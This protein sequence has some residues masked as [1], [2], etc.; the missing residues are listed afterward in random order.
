MHVLF[1]ILFY[2][3]FLL[4]VV[5]LA[6]KIKQYAQT[7]AP[8]KIPTTPAPVT[9]TGVVWRL[10]T[11]VVFFNSLWKSNKW[12]WIFGWIF[13]FALLLAFFRHLRYVIPEGSFIFPLVDN[14]LVLTAGK[15]AGWAMLFGLGGLF[16]RRIVVDRVRYISSPSDFAM[17]LLIMGIALT[18]VLV[19]FV[20]RDAFAIVQLK[21]FV[22]GLLTLNWQP[23]PDNGL[24]ITHLSLVLIL[25]VIFPVSKLLHAPG[26]F[27]SPS[28]NQ[29]DNPREQR[30]VAPWARKLESGN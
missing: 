11:E 6:Y 17:L 7:P 9:R 5:G 26:V 13:H 29:V 28:R 27:F 18:G 14:W 23:V 30:H 16:V 12:I 4:L 24:I 15:Y 19:S 3:A 21:A 8:L 10:F 20:F 25:M 22:I 2:A 1:G